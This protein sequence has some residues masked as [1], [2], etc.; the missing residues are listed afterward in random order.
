MDG[1]GGQTWVYADSLTPAQAQLFFSSSSGIG[2]QYVRTANTYNGVQPDLVTLQNAGALGA[3]I[4]LGLQSPPCTLKHSYVELG[5]ACTDPSNSSSAFYDGSLSSNGTCLTSSQSLATSYA[6]WATYIVDYVNTLAT[7]V[8]YPVSVLDVQNEPDNSPNISNLGACGLPASAYDTFIGTYLGPALAGASWNSTQGNAPKIMMAS[9]ADTFP[10]H[11]W[12]STCL[13][14]TTC[15]Q[16]VSIVSGHS[17]DN[18]VSAFPSVSYNSGRH[19]WASETDPAESHP[20]DA[21]MTNAL[22]VAQNIHNYMANENVSGYERWELAYDAVTNGGYNFG[23]T[24]SSFNPAKRYYVFGNWSKFI[25][26]G[27][28]RIDATANPQSGVYVTAFKDPGD[29]SF[30]IVAINTN[31]DT[32]SQTFTLSEFPTTTSVIAY[33]TSS[34][35]SLAAQPSTGVSGSAFNYSLPAQSVATFVG[36]TSGSGTTAGPVAPPSGLKVSV[37]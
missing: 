27:W 25:Q 35:L 1:F 18:A 31:G 10:Y 6:T 16:Y 15:A 23:L 24:D 14:D 9:Q 22:G 20:Y 12:A 8:G 4:E 11:D 29:T 33:V 21:T 5:E 26:T 2:L 30:I 36:T 34:T 7:S 37:Q 32:T 13:N 17:L 19:V 3:K 28:M